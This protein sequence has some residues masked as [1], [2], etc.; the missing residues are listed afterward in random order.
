VVGRVT[1]VI[2]IDALGS[3]VAAAHDFLRKRPGQAYRLQT[4]IGYS[5]SA[6]PSLLTGLLPRDHGHFSMYHRDVG[7]GVFRAWRPLMRLAHRFRG[8]GRLRRLLK[9]R[10]T[11]RIGGYFELY[12]IPLNVLSQFDLCQREDIFTPGGVPPRNTFIDTLDRSGI[13]HRIWSWKAEEETAYRELLAD[14]REE[15]SDFLLLYSAKLDA[16]MHQVGVEGPR[17]GEM[18]RQYEGWVDQMAAAAGD[19]ELHLYVFS[20]H[21]MTDVREEHDVHRALDITGLR[22]PEDYLVFTDSTMARFWFRSPTAEG[23]IRRALPDGPWGRWLSDEEM[24]SYGIDFPDRRYGEAIFLLEAGHIIV[25][26]FMGTTGCAAMHG[27]GPEDV[28]TEAWLFASPPV[29]PAP[30]TILDLRR[31]FETEITELARQQTE[32]ST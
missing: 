1:V 16:L 30:R 19:R 18:L 8:R 14:L 5:S 22:M 9:T 2:F 13:P 31:M 3:E 20:D 26:S 27:Y 24:R 6:I 10:L 12:D 11:Q 23:A 21:G 28:T 25:P 7:D 32:R 4:V 15:R 17:V 29:D